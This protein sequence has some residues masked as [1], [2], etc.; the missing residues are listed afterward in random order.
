MLLSGSLFI[1]CAGFAQQ[2]D[3]PVDWAR[4]GRYAKANE[5]LAAPPGAVFLGNSITEGWWMVDSA[6]FKDNNYLARGISGQ[7]TAEMLVRFRADVINLKPKAVVI[8]AGT[9]DIAQNIGYI[10]EENIFGNIVSMAELAKVH[11]ILPVLCS[12]LP[13]YDYRWRPGLEPAGKIIRLNNRMKE[14]AAENGCVYVDYHSALKDGRNGLPEKYSY[15]GVH[16]NPAG[17]RIMEEIV[18]D[19]L[20][21]ALK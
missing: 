6:F 13:V 15:D 7:T 8:L 17:Y 5:Q 12:I 14:Y 11:H 16:V 9:N 19:A 3:A 10:S 4:F 20:L 18:Q 2:S 21:K 1:T